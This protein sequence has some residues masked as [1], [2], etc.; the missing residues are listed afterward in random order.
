M[1]QTDRLIL[2][3]WCDADRPA[4]AAMNADPEVMHDYPAPL[5]RAECDLQLDR[6]QAAIERLGYGRWAMERREDGLFLGYVGAMP[7][8]NDHPC[9]PG[10]EIGWRMIRAAWGFGYA[11]EGAAAALRDGFA[12]L[13]FAE[14]TAYTAPTNARSRAVMRR[15]GMARDASRDFEHPSAGPFVVYVARPPKATLTERYSYHDRSVC[16]R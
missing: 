14:I 1:I 13:G 8:F 5:T 12:R 9:A 11:S 3:P 4:F 7:I 6:Y 16:S 10:A 15:L 2:R